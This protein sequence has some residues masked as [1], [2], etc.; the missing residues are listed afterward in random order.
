MSRGYK[1]LQ[2]ALRSKHQIKARSRTAV[3]D[4]IS[5][6]ASSY[7]SG[8]SGSLFSVGSKFQNVDPTQWQGTWSGTDS[9]KQPFSLSVSNVK[10]YRADV[11]LKD[12]SG[13][14]SSRVFI[15]S[16]NTF[17]IGDSKFI[18][19]AK[20]QGTLASVVT[21]P[22]NGDQTLVQALATLKS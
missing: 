9:G 8:T 14:Q 16:Q 11:T 5:T 17:R 22:Y 15:T 10:G 1:E 4:I 13:I 18:L 6:L 21:N 3:A 12:S 2:K 20:G 19:T 7:T